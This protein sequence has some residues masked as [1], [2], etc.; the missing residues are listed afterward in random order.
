MR[1]WSITTRLT[2]TLVAGSLG[3]CFLAIMVFL[4][5]QRAAAAAGRVSDEVFPAYVALANVEAGQ[6]EVQRELATL[7]G[8][9]GISEARRAEHYKLL[10]QAIRRVERGAAD[11]Q[12]TNQRGEVQRL[13]AEAWPALKSWLE[14]ARELEATFHARD[15]AAS[16][17]AL[18]AISTKLERDWSRLVAESGT[19][20]A[21]VM[22]VM[23][24]NDADVAAA[25]VGEHEAL[26]A[27]RFWLLVGMLGGS[28]AVVLGGLFMVQRLRAEIGILAEEAHHLTEAVKRGKLDVRADVTRALPDLVPALQ[29]MN[30]TLDA[31]LV[32][33]NMTSECVAR[34]GRGDLPEP[35]TTDMQGQFGLIRDSLNACIVAVGGLVE[36]LHAMAA[37]HARGQTDVTISEAR[38]QGA[39]A[40]VARSVNGMVA[41]HISDAGR[42]LAAFDAF[43]QGNFA[44]QM[45]RL[46]G[47]KAAIN[48][49]V[50]RVRA[51]LDGFISAMGRMS[52]QQAAGDFEAILDE[53]AF[54]GDWQRMADAVNGLAMRNAAVTSA[55]LAAVDAFG[56]G[57]F[58][59]SLEQFPGKLTVINQTVEQVRQNLQALIADADALAVAAREGR[60]TARVDPE[61]HQGDFRRIVE[62]MNQTFDSMHAPIKAASSVLQRMAARDI[63]S[64][65]QGRFAGDHAALTHAVNGTADALA[66]A[67][68]QVTV[69]VHQVSTAAD[70][71]AA[72]STSVASGASAQAG[73][74]ERINVT[75]E[76]IAEQTRR[77]A[78]SA[79]RADQLARQA[80]GEAQKGT[81]TM[82]GMTEAMGRIRASAEG[83]STI[84]KDIN[85]I[86]F[87]TNLLA[88]NAAVEAA[89]A[90]EAGRGFAVVAEEV[91]SLALRAKEAAQ[92]TEVL[93][94]QSV[95]QASG[96]EVMAREVASLLE[97]IRVHVGGVTEAVGGIASSARGQA[98]VIEE[99]EKSVSEV[100]Q[101][102]QQTAASAEQ[103]SS[104]AIELNGQAEDLGGMVGT[105]RLEQ[106]ASAALGPARGT[107]PSLR[108]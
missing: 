71:I 26:A 11:Y 57:D 59:A 24:Q 83:T 61:R 68:T 106:G 36:E 104:A 96:G 6:A 29:G 2:L 55:V 75:L 20:D 34:I 98:K 66:S 33:M 79:E 14:R 30:Q 64:R 103:S 78:D 10:D 86:A 19:S 23:D 69:A 17:A 102:M 107:R 108:S 22:K 67:L 82:G 62:G 5:S 97:K 44:V 21:L 76:G 77:S 52:A 72:A 31:L 54:A 56:R 41:G 90:G 16:G 88:L 49:T 46:P 50:E 51:N 37:A 13:W 12:K 48:E 1:R 43:G 74:V 92:K 58:G 47:K 38:F 89:R 63:T 65:V 39:F 3:A 87:Q 9:E 84:I 4:A 99:L 91:R 45:E 7:E 85:D 81:D 15:V 40:E 28:V 8:N 95:Q 18:E 53:A 70:E 73:A 101:S 100:D 35:I 80:H 105:F 25:R 93:I 42:A 32:P 27:A 94:H 60:L